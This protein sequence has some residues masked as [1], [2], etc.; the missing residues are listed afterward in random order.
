MKHPVRGRCGVSATGRVYDRAGERR[1]LTVAVSRR[2]ARLPSAGVGHGCR[3]PASGTV[4]AV[5]RR[6]APAGVTFAAGAVFRSGFLADASAAGFAVAFLVVGFLVEGFLVEG[7]LVAVFV[8]ALADDD[9][10]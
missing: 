7:F 5:E 10:A 2:R 9:A 3:Q 6:D 8:A 1:R 4:A